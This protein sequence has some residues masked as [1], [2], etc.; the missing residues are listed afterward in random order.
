MTLQIVVTLVS[1][2]LE[3]GQSFFVTSGVVSRWALMG[4]Q[5]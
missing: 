3:K 1:F 4:S 2:G 5:V